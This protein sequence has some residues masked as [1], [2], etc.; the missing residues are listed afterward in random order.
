[1]TTY[2]IELELARSAIALASTSS[3]NQEVA[4]T[5]RI[6]QRMERAYRANGY[7]EN[8]AVARILSEYVPAD[9]TS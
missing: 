7:G 4:K 6:I 5:I 9:G 3:N 1:M 8:N 2:P